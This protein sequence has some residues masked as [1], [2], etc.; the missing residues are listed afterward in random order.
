MGRL[1]G[2]A[3]A[4]REQEQRA[5]RDEVGQMQPQQHNF[6]TAHIPKPPLAGTN[7]PIR[8]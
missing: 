2:L 7:F 5:D 1:A 8:Y 3:R 6:H 4:G